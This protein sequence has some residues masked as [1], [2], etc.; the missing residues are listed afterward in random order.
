MS[1]KRNFLDTRHGHGSSYLEED[2]NNIKRLNCPFCGMITEC[3]RFVVGG[4]T[5]RTR[6][7][8][9]TNCN[10]KF[11]GKILKSEKRSKD[12]KKAVAIQRVYDEIWSWMRDN[13]YKMLDFDTLPKFMIHKGIIGFPRRHKGK[14]LN[15]ELHPQFLSYLD[16]PKFIKSLAIAMTKLEQ[17]D[18]KLYIFI[19]MKSLDYTL[20]DIQDVVNLK[21][22]KTRER[23]VSGLGRKKISSR[24]N[25]AIKYNRKAINFIIDSVPLNVR[26]QWNIDSLQFSK[27][28]PDF[29]NEKRVLCPKCKGKDKSC[30][31]CFT[32]KRGWDGTVPIGF[33][34]MYK[35][36]IE[37][38]TWID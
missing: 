5:Q 24:T 31:L 21:L 25:A 15:T 19:V 33:A 14:K 27:P 18:L 8:K 3:K 36:K 2:N 16:T 10:Q 7:Y 32:P 35:E 28:K 23:N 37:K 30:S 12:D 6:F 1:K 17:D 11:Y 9:C 20:S 4:T 26:S 13:I 29:E 38:G 34:K 22:I